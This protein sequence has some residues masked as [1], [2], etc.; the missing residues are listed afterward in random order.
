MATENQ[1]TISQADHGVRH[2][3][4][5]Q[6]SQCPGAGRVVEVQDLGRQEIIHNGPIRTNTTGDEEDICKNKTQV[7]L[8]ES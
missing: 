7:R 2:S 4:F 1:R 8:G 6:I 3:W 5:W